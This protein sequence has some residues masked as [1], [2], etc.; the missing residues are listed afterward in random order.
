MKLKISHK[1]YLSSI[2]QLLLIVLIGSVGI[3][4]MDKIGK[5]LFDIAEEDIPLTKSLTLITE[6]QLQESILFERALLKA[7]K[8]SLGSYKAKQEF[9]ALEAQILETTPKVLKEIQDAENFIVE[10]LKHLHS[11][12]AKSE[13]NAL[14]K[15]LKAIDAEYQILIESVASTLKLSHDGEMDAAYIEA[16]T[17][18]ALQDKIDHHLIESLNSIQNFTLASA[19]KAVEEQS[20]VAIQIKDSVENIKNIAEDT[21][22]NTDTTANANEKIAQ[23]LVDLHVNLNQ[24]QI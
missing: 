10:A 11:E 3:I 17:T 13:Y 24:F 8:A 6:H 5:Q 4:Q 20:I 19:L 18:E 14:Y 21:K 2:V 22:Q 16:V 1:L 12:E 15:K 9:L 7:L 23:R